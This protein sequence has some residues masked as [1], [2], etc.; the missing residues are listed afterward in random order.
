[1]TMLRCLTYSNPML[2]PQYWDVFFG[3]WIHQLPDAIVNIASLLSNTAASCRISLYS[4]RSCSLYAC[5]L[6]CQ[7]HILTGRGAKWTDYDNIYVAPIGQA[8]AV[9]IIKMDLKV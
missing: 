9:V 6:P 5:L 2:Q 3:Y 1:M 4:L 7:T 8:A